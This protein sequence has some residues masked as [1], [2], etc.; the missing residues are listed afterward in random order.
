MTYRLHSLSARVILGPKCALFLPLLSGLM[1][2]HLCLWES[3]RSPSK[4][5]ERTGTIVGVTMWRIYRDTAPSGPCLRTHRSEVQGRAQSSGI[6]DPGPAMVQGWSCSPRPLGEAQSPELARGLRETSKEEDDGRKRRCQ[7]KGHRMTGCENKVDTEV[8]VGHT[9][10]PKERQNL[11]I[12]GFN[13][14]QICRTWGMR[15]QKDNGMRE[16]QG[17]SDRI[18][19]ISKDPTPSGTAQ[20]RHI[21]VKTDPLAQDPDIP[22]TTVSG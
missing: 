15:L 7:R 9:S 21:W 10:C 17:Q 13:A 1:S 18:Y 4:R 11:W 3:L 2:V 8:S 5:E 14:K 12:E 22:S 19:M 16:T 6:Q 20:E